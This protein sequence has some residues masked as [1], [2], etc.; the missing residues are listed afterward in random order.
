M[1]QQ[2]LAASHVATLRSHGW[3]IARL[4]VQADFLQLMGSGTAEKFTG[5]IVFDLSQLAQRLDPLV[6][7]DDRKFSGR[8]PR[9]SP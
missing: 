3:Q 4:Q 1:W 5:Q 6:D 9:I 7:L 2:P 8:G